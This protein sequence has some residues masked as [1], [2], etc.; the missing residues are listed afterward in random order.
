MLAADALK[1]M[2]A[3]AKAEIGVDLLVASGWRPHRWTSREDYEAEMIRRYGSVAE[4]QR[5]VA[6]DSPHETGLAL[7]FGS[8]GLRPDRST[9]EQQRATPLYSW[10]AD[11]AHR[12]GFYPYKLE[13]WHWEFPLSVEAWRT[14]VVN[15]GTLSTNA[16][17]RGDMRLIGWALL[18]LLILL[19]SV[20]PRGRRSLALADPQRGTSRRLRSPRRPNR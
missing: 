1:Q 3:A 6:Y 15:Q 16:T 9:A 10:L 20:V 12:F 2:A 5:W 14:G 19:V 8:G 18:C 13:P 4:G 7:D 17:G 11:N